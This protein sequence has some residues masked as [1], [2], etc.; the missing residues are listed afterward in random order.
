MPSRRKCSIVREPSVLPFGCQRVVSSVLKSTDR[1]PCQSRNKASIIPTGPPPTM[2]TGTVLA[3]ESDMIC[4]RQY[5]SRSVA[6]AR[7][8]NTEKA[9][10]HRAD[11]LVARLAMKPVVPVLVDFDLRQLDRRPDDLKIEIL[12]QHAR[13]GYRQG[14]NRIGVLGN[15][16]GSNEGRDTADDVLWPDGRLDRTLGKLVRVAGAER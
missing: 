6:R 2:A 12:G 9:G 13:D 15:H 8:R 7:S 4:W 1:T 14:C 11:P 3:S 5:S 10:E 16:C